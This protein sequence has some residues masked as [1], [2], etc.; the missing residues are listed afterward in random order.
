MDCSLYLRARY[1]DARYMK[2]RLYQNLAFLR[3][4]KYNFYEKNFNII[5]SKG[6]LVWDHIRHKSGAQNFV[7]KYKM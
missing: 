1:I 3:D 2:I 7:N 4:F 6:T 5:D